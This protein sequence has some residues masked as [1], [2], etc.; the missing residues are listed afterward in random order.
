MV[1]KHGILSTPALSR[2]IRSRKYNGGGRIHGGIILTASHNPGGPKH[3]FGIKFNCENGGP[4]P[5]QVT[6]RIHALTKTISEY[7]ICPELNVDFGQ[8]GLSC[9]HVEGVGN[10]TVQVIDGVD[11]YVD[12]MEE[13]FDFVEV[14]FGPKAVRCVVQ[15]GKG[16]CKMGKVVKNTVCDTFWIAYCNVANS[17]LPEI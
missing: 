8:V 17:K 13:I 11:D 12:Y 9:V 6:D 7:R 16:C 5:D 1:A 3:D 14:S 2:L 15:H 4:A 10:F